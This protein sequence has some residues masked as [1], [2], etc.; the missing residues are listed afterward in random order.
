[1]ADMDIDAPDTPSL[2]Q[3]VAALL[4]EHPRLNSSVKVCQKLGIP[5]G[6]RGRVYEIMASLGRIPKAKHPLGT[7]EQRKA[8]SAKLKQDMAT[9]ELT[10]TVGAE[11]HELER[12]I[13]EGNRDD[14]PSL[15]ATVEKASLLALLSPSL[16]AS[17][18]VKELRENVRVMHEI[19]HPTPTAN[20]TTNVSVQQSVGILAPAETQR[21]IAE[22]RMK[23]ALT[24]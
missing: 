10:E 5:K 15:V 2:R 3:R 14:V 24:P 23:R 17:A 8:R 11:L 16:L 1:M 20:V 7:P 13:Q 22:L 21:R 6:K 4:E 9:R 12:V 19:L 18:S